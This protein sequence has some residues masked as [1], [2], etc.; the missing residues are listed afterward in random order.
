VTAK[1][2]AWCADRECEHE[3]WLSGRVAAFLNVTPATWNRYWHP[4]ANRPVFVHNP[5][6]QPDDWFD[7]RTA[8]WWECTIRRW[9]AA[10]PGPGKR[11]KA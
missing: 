1:H 5:A 6:P 3:Q 8:W 7:R 9:N 2:P 4:P 11:V 10:R